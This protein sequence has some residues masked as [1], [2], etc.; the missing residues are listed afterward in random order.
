MPNNSWNE[1]KLSRD[2]Q[3]QRKRMAVLRTGARL[4]NERGF[5]RTS[6][7]DIANELNVSK[8][9]LYYYVEN[10]DDILFQCSRLAMEFMSDEIIKSKETASPALQR[11]ES[12]MRVY[13]ELLS[14][15]F[16][17]CL[18]LCQ[19]DVLSN[20]NQKILRQERTILDHRVRDLINEGMEDG[21]ISPCD[22]KYA[23]AAIFGAFN[24]VPYWNKASNTQPYNEVAD[25]FLKIY[26]KGLSA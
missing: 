10:K 24:W 11:I 14:N 5:D 7:V 3:R 16:G 6:L 22:P 9:T 1:E 2:E 21:S 19:D 8:R 25:Q 13:M 15:E 26:I 12:L 20:E 18:V 4:F 23:T 17:S